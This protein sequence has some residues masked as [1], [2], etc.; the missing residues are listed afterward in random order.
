MKHVQRSTMV[1]IAIFV[2][3]G[4]LYVF[5]RPEESSVPASS[6]IPVFVVTTTITETTL[7]GGGATSVPITETT[8]PS[9]D[10]PTVDSQPTSETSAPNT[11]ATTGTTTG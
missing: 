5:V 2:A 3:A 10:G 6:P 4:A 8:L 11:V 9:A 7:E 1:A